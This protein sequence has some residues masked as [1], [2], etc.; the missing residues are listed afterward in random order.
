MKPVNVA[1]T[2]DVENPQTPLLE[3]RF[4]DNRI[5]SDGHAIERIMEILSACG[6]VG[7][8]FANV[9]EY[10]VWG[11]GEM[12]RIV[13][14]VHDAGHH[15]ELHTHP[16]WIDE[17]RRENMHQFPAAEQE[18]IV[19]FGADF[20]ESCT[21]RRP[22]CHRAGGYGFNLDTLAACRKA[23]IEID[24]SNFHGHPNC[25]ADVAENQPVQAGGILELPV[26]FVRSGGR[27]VKTDLDWMSEDDFRA[28][29][30]AVRG[31]PS[32]DFV[33]FFFHSYSLTRTSDGFRTFSPDPAKVAKLRSILTWLRGSAD[34][35]IVP[36]ADLGETYGGAAGPAADPSQDQGRRH[37][38]APA[39][40][41]S[42]SVRDER[43]EVLFVK[44]RPQVRIYKEAKA[45]R[46]TGRYRLVL[47][48]WLTDRPFFEEV[49][50]EILP[51][52]SQR[53]L[54]AVVS[55]RS[56]YV[57]H[58]HA[59]PNSVP[60]LVMRGAS[61]PVVFDAYDFTGISSGMQHEN[62]EEL[63]A[64]R[65]CFENAAGVVRKG[66]PFEI[67]YYRRRGY[68]I[69]CPET[70]W[71]D[72]CDEELFAEES[73]EKLSARDGEVHLV[74]AGNF[75]ASPQGGHSFIYFVPLARA[76]AEQGIHLHLYANPWQRV[77]ASRYVELARTCRHLH[78]H[79]P[80]PYRHLSG[81]IARYDYGLLI[82]PV[83]GCGEV[84]RA[85]KDKLKVA[86]G[87]K[88]PAYMEA[89]IP[90][91][92][93]DHLEFAKSFVVS[94]GIGFAVRDDDLDRLGEVLAGADREMMRSNTLRARRE[95][96]LA[97][98]APRLE[99]FYET[100]SRRHC[101]SAA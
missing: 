65:F 89:G 69:D 57:V 31:A 64:E 27:S 17:K 100:V 22:V 10:A 79:D 30:E 32:R 42:I 48:S 11:R 96:S 9:Y 84:P 18:A 62:P 19:T 66:P 23:G 82:H 68:V 45:L 73:V 7:T 3:K 56:P 85:S 26:T 54:L 2:I 99:A 16:I 33:N 39:G 15:V 76:L 71:I 21:G 59:E 86:F 81:H 44:P 75:A 72:Y 83:H 8:L 41:V 91:I 67:D 35:R 61:A 36:L 74:Y 87:N 97:A 1:I 98:Q 5:W 24:S 28:F 14:T 13:K 58:A 46:T 63:A 4:G 49:F 12:Q 43:P 101:A 50:D 51:W 92:V 93:S 55:G 25:C 88:V 78:L 34:C 77:D 40:P 6:A 29:V 20:I 47:A 94:S 60:A 38:P 37:E 70:Q 80:V 52:K 53:D 90:V 95:M